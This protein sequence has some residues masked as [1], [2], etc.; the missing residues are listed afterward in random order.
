MRIFTENNAFHNIQKCLDTQ[1]TDVCQA[2]DF[3]QFCVQIILYDRIDITPL[4]QR[5]ITDVTSALIQRLANEYEITNVFQVP[6]VDSEFIGTMKDVISDVDRIVQDEVGNFLTECEQF[7]LSYPNYKDN[8][9]SLLPTLDSDTIGQIKFATKMIETKNKDF[10]VSQRP[11]STYDTD[12]G[13]TRIVS[14]DDTL[15]TI[16]S[17]VD[18]KG[19]DI[20]TTSYLIARIRYLLNN[21]LCESLAKKVGKIGYSPSAIRGRIVQPT[22]TY[23]RS[24]DIVI[25][26][27][28]ELKGEECRR[29]CF[30]QYFGG[31][32][33]PSLA[34]FLIET[35]K[36]KVSDILKKTAELRQTFSDL[37][38][39]LW[40]SDKSPQEQIKEIL[41]NLIKHNGISGQEIAVVKHA[42]AGSSIELGFVG[43]M[44]TGKVSVSSGDLSAI[45]SKCRDK[46]RT[47]FLGEKNPPK[48][49]VALTEIADFAFNRQDHFTKVFIRDCGI[50][51]Y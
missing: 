38:G 6:K 40:S 39:V 16:F 43:P 8:P 46:L 48:H 27:L 2:E 5:E 50:T 44:P 31:V 11:M 14:Q 42:P 41:A 26:R 37:R 10:F 34:H 15:E 7:Y 20:S 4:V 32:V 47:L 51:N 13:V 9:I 28:I 19:W 12:S 30:D 35:G 1:C 36:G 17:V 21:Q 22:N 24:L 3:L 45:L 49:I 18:S 25:R 33:M 29:D 23:L